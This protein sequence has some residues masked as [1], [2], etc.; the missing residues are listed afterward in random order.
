M[1]G[2]DGLSGSPRRS[3][4]MA[5]YLETPSPEDRI[6][7][8]RIHALLR[9]GLKSEAACELEEVELLDGRPEKQLLR[10]RVLHASG[11]F[12][13]AVKAYD[14]LLRSFRNALPSGF[15]RILYP[16]RY[17]DEARGLPKKPKC[18]PIS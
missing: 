6:Q 14:N 7:I 13:V 16:I 2:S 5:S 10:A 9:V 17:H 11:Q 8:A 3:T 15:E 12:L 1:S 18:V 4:E